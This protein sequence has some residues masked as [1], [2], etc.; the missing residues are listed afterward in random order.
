MKQINKTKLTSM[1]ACLFLFTL[2][3]SNPLRA[4]QFS[5]WNVGQGQWATWIREKQCLHFDMGGEI[6][7]WQKITQACSG[8]ENLVFLSHWDWDHIGLVKSASYHLKGLCI[9]KPPAGASP[10]SKKDELLQT[11]PSCSQT[12][13]DDVNHQDLVEL[14]PATA[15]EASSNEKSR[16]FQI[17]HFVVVPGDSTIGAERH[18]AAKLPLPRLPTPQNQMTTLVLGHHGSHT[19][20]SEF[21]LK[22]LPNLK[23]AISSARKARYGHPHLSVALALQRHGVA[24]IRTEDWGHVIQELPSATRAFSKNKSIAEP[25]NKFHEV[26]KGKGTL[27]TRVVTEICLHSNSQKTKPDGG[28]SPGLNTQGIFFARGFKR[29]KACNPYL[30]YEQLAHK[31]HVHHRH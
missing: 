14:T 28:A 27:Q 7:P 6:A 2:L 20:T 3:I 17:A 31:L 13:I 16:V 9:A 5:V 30:S 23:Q 18:W 21:L 11:I 4:E 15:V 10:N 26:K 24:L 19:S 8:K 12:L 29:D 25:T 1:Q 22:H